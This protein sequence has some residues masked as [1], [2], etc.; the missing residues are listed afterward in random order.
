MT[1]VFVMDFDPDEL[2]MGDMEDFYD[3]AGRTVEEALTAYPLKDP[4]TGEKLLDERGRPITG[5]RIRPK[6]MTGFIWLTKRREDPTF[7]YE[8][9]R[10]VKVKQLTIPQRDTDAS[11]ESEGND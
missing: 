9:A 11:K 6:E 1:D 2:S 10:S 3:L 5:V 4:D 8:Q 7:T